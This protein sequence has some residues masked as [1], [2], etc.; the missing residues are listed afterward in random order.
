MTITTESKRGSDC[1]GSDGGTSR[2]LTLA[3]TALTIGEAFSVYVNGLLLVLTTEY[4]ISHLSASTTVTFVGAKWDSDYII[5]NYMATGGTPSYGS[6][7]TYTNV[8][9][10]SG[11]STTEVSSAI[12]NLLIVDA[13]AELEAITGRKFTNANT[14]TDFLSISDKDLVGN[15]QSRFMTTMWPLQSITECITLDQ[16]GDTVDTFDTLSSAEIV[17]GTYESADYWVEV[18]NDTMVNALKPTRR[19]VLKTKTLSEGVNKVKI[20]YTYGYTTVPVMITDLASAM[21]GIRAWISFLGGQ[22]DNVNSYNLAEF[23]ANK[24]DIYTKGLQN[25][26]ALRMKI[27][28]LL[29]RIGRKS[30]TLFYATGQD[31]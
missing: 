29:D 23:A 2:V 30:R 22:Y 27:D 8:Y 24:G 18:Q 20:A 11:L 31:R 3:N 21:A 19:I 28:S 6:Y 4:T 13:E 7:C 26:T 9:N 25:M 17:A 5:V 15:N 10:R 14:Y 1:S 12:V 16:D